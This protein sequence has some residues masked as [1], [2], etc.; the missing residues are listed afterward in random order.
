MIHNIIY[1]DI[2][3]RVPYYSFYILGCLVLSIF[4]PISFLIF[5]MFILLMRINHIC[6]NKELHSGLFQFYFMLPVTRKNIVLGK[7]L[8]LMLVLLITMTGVYLGSTLGNM[9]EI[10]KVTEGL[11]KEYEI[12]FP[13]LGILLG[14]ILLTNIQYFY[15][16]LPYDEIISKNRVMIFIVFVLM[17]ILV[18]ILND[19]TISL[20]LI[21]LLERNRLSILLFSNIYFFTGTYITSN[22][23]ESMDCNYD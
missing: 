15:F 7:N 4:I 11:T 17:I 3:N 14:S 5:V 16:T 12:L 6:C 22:K 1:L 2:K 8:S 10:S 21:T 18:Q 20:R 19:S 9:L 23:V 13:Y